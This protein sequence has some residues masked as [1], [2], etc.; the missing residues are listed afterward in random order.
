MQEYE[1][2]N[3]EAS[4]VRT[5]RDLPMYTT[6]EPLN[7]NNQVYYSFTSDS[8]ELFDFQNELQNDYISRVN[9][10][11]NEEHYD[12]TYI[13]VDNSQT[14]IKPSLTSKVS[15]DLNLINEI[16][17]SRNQN[18]VLSHVTVKF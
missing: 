2:I 7:I 12:R 6:I 8:Q 9:V 10:K 1:L 4:P 11:N 17:S 15:R 3:P 5:K 14:N 18:D 13:R 16:E